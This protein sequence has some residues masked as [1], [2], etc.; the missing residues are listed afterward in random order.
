MT[1]TDALGASVV[2]LF[3]C[4]ANGTAQIAWKTPL[5]PADQPIAEVHALSPADSMVHLAGRADASHAVM[6]F[7]HP[8]SDQLRADLAARGV[9]LISYLPSNAYV[10]SLRAEVANRT[11]AEQVWRDVTNAQNQIQSIRVLEASQK[12]HPALTAPE[13]PPWAIVPGTE[14]PDP[15]VI[16]SLQ[17]HDDV[18][19]DNRVLSAW[20][21]YGVRIV[22]A[23]ASSNVV[24]AE[25]PASRL[26][27]IAADDRVLWMEPV[28]PPLTD[29]NAE[30]R[31]A[32]GVSILQAS[33]YSLSGTGITALVFDGGRARAT[34]LDFQGRLTWLAGDASPITD[35]ASHVAATLGGGGIADST[36]KGMAPGVRLLS[37]G[38]E[39]SG[40]GLLYTNPGDIESNYLSAIMAGADLANNSI[41]SNVEI[42]AYDCSWQG[43]YGVTD[44]LLDNIARGSLGKPLI[45]VWAAG[46]ERQGSRCD[47]EGVGDYASVAPPA[48]AKNIITVGAVNANDLSMTEFSSWGPTDDGRLVPL[49]VAPGCKTIGNTGIRSA[50]A[51]ADSSYTVMCGTSMASPVVAGVVSLALQDYRATFQT[52]Q[53]PSPSMM[54]A[55]LAHSATDLGSPGPD[56]Q[57]G[58]GNVNGPALVELV[59]SGKHFSDSISAAASNNYALNVAAGQSQIRITIAWDDVAAS[60][61]VQTALVNDLDLVLRAPNGTLYYPWTLNQ[62]SPAS[63][64]VATTANKVDNI[65]QVVVNN[66]QAGLW[67]VQVRG[68]NVPFGPQSYSVVGM[69]LPS[70]VVAEVSTPGP[71][72]PAGQSTT[73][74]LRRL[75]SPQSINVAASK[76]LHRF[77]PSTLFTESPLMLNAD[78]LTGVLPAAKC[79]ET[80]EYAFK[81]SGPGL[82]TMY[83][84]AQKRA[85]GASTTL[86]S[87]DFNSS[88]GWTVL[89]EGALSHGWWE[90]A[91]PGNFGR[92]D[93]PGD[94]DASGKCFVTENTFNEDLDGGPTSLISP[95]INTTSGTS[96]VLSYARWFYCNDGGNTLEEDFMTVS[97]SIDGGLSWTQLERVYT[98]E[99][100]RRVS[101]AIPRSTLF[102]IKFTVSDSPNNSLVE[103]AIDSVSIT[104]TSCTPI[105]PSDVNRSGEVDFADWIDFF[106]GYDTL[107]PPADCDV[108]GD[109]D[110]GDF[111]IFLA[112]FTEGCGA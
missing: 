10:V 55:W 24:V 36:E 108:D 78:V 77:S 51:L 63:G 93:P 7:A 49:I 83:I 14:G 42:N 25:V 99:G 39:Y 109:V 20:Q 76:L 43:K 1:R 13:R 72:L 16:V 28:L 6:Q 96:P 27:L 12:L 69:A 46:N 89:N 112:D 18:S 86:F 80:P 38:F 57:F 61:G 22:G 100:W 44:A 102:R 88:Q 60:P 47:V 91:T 15:T 68:S 74:Q 59:R 73:L 65:E 34:H 32:S 103:A 71:Y 33:P 52:T 81:I 75:S 23:A 107:Q 54:R 5:E 110:L 41:G 8:V 105:C 48:G 9:S 92:Y 84:P 104:A 2:T 31:Q 85:V 101:A 50:S 40:T 82:G 79:G 37:G 106:N 21:K 64:A 67:T 58:Y 35:H 30:S 11:V 4:C 95:I 29:T 3:L 53:N 87:D 26:S 94:F 56:F 66:P 17:C 90:R 70:L 45:M 62:Q 97:T 111:L 19:I 98:T